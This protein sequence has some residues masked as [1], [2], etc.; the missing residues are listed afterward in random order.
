MIRRFFRWYFREWNSK[1]MTP[2]RRRALFYGWMFVCGV[3]FASGA[4]VSWGTVGLFIFGASIVAL[5]PVLFVPSRK[6][7]GPSETR[8]ELES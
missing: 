1:E 6:A 7:L 4:F 3:A 2:A 5:G 8:G